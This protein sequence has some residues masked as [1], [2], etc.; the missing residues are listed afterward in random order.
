M[1]CTLTVLA[2]QVTDQ[3]SNDP[4]DNMAVNFTVGFSTGD[5]C[6]APYTPI[7]D[8]QGNGATAA[9]TGTVT[10][11]GVVVGDYEGASPALRGFFLQD[12]SGDD[13]PATSDGIF[14]FNGNNNNVNL[15][16]VVRVTG[17]AE[18]FQGQT[19]ISSVTSIVNCGT[20]SVDPTDV[21][22]PFA[23]ADSPEHYEG[24]LVRL[25]QT[26]YVTEH[27]Q[28]GRFGQVVLSSGGRLKQPTNV[29]APGAASAGAAGR[30]RPE[31]DH[32]R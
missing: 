31:P 18:E 16:D 14:V 24:M 13:D 1:I 11:Q 23:S 26:L 12:L 9:I 29:V 32:R 10:T 30:K 2:A 7:Y 17:K 5:A 20:G 19:Q 8:I 28:L 6:L 27:F 25:P 21:T 22:L 3:D 4:P 15:G